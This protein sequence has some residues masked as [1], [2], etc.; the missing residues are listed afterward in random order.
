MAQQHGARRQ[1]L[2]LGHPDIVGIEHLDQVVAQHAHRGDRHDDGQRDGRQGHGPQILERGRAFVDAA[3][4]RETAGIATMKAISSSVPSRK[5]GIDRRTRLITEM[6]WSTGRS[7]CTAWMSAGMSASGQVDQEGV[8]RQQQGVED[9]RRQD[10]GDRARAG[11]RIAEIAVQDAAEPMDISH[12]R[13]VV[14]VQLLAQEG[15]RLRRRIAPQH[16]RGDVARQHLDD[17]KNDDRDDEQREHRQQNSRDQQPQDDHARFP[18][19]P[20]AQS[21]KFLETAETTTSG[22][23]RRILPA[24]LSTAGTRLAPGVNYCSHE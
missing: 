21:M 2:E 24:S 5:S 4:R 13:R 3:R 20:G 18:F 7:R 1:A 22:N 8:D 19:T 15:N 12:H 11:E 23:S 17:R 14:E 10:I 6:T 9:A 16:A